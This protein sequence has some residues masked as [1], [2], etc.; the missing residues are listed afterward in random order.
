LINDVSEPS[1]EDGWATFKDLTIVGGNSQYAYIFFVVDG[2][3][4]LRWGSVNFPLAEQFNLPYYV[5]PI[6]LSTT[7]STVEVINT[8]STTVVEGQ[9]LAVQPK[10]RVLGN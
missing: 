2:K 8:P 4:V 6:L 1:G 9:P 5:Q 7:V 10:I 3:T